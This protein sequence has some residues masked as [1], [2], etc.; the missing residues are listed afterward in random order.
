M[1]KKYKKILIVQTAFNG[2][3]VLTTPL[4]LATKGIFSEAQLSV[5]TNPRGRELLE[6]LAEVNEVIVYDKRGRDRGALGFFSIIK[7][8]RTKAFELC[9]CPHRSY[10]TALLTYLAGIPIR[11]GYYES[12]FNFL[13]TLRVHRDGSLHEVMRGLSLLSPF[14]MEIGPREHRP[15]LCVAPGVNEWVDGLFDEAG[16]KGEG[17]LVGISPGSV[18]NTKRWIP[19]GFAMVAETLE[20]EYGARV[21][22][23][24]GTEDFEVAQQILTLTRAKPINLVGKTTLKQL[25]GVME[26]LNLFVSND[27]GTMHIA[28]ARGVPVVAIFGPTVPEMGFAP[29]DKNSRV[30]EKKG[31]Y[32]RPCNPHGP[33]VCP[34]GHFQCMRSISPAQV[35][36]A[37]GEL[38]K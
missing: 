28:V 11:I 13:Y 18:W 34:E 15:F 25:V 7:E 1:L 9:I 12:S 37:V 14:G 31:L 29:F 16:I 30:L 35:L 19:E 8:L 5:L 3:V 10:R 20:R 22:L 36:E 6:D 17:L 33:R 27:T 23:L 24:G 32:C 4:I 2:D 21:L 38:I 26:R